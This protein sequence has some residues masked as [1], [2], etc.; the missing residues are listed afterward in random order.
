MGGCAMIGQSME[1]IESGARTRVSSLVAGIV[2]FC[3]LMGS[4]ILD[5]IPI[6]ALVG[7]TFQR[8]DL[9]KKKEER[10]RKKKKEEERRRRR[11]KEEERRR[12]KKKKE[13]E[14]RR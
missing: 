9:T 4:Q 11:K 14:R 3:I 13:E 10:R 1:N 5:Y 7:V 6:A 8:V 12:K 2:T